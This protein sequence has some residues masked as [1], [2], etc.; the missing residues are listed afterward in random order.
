MSRNLSC[1]LATLC[2]LGPATP[3]AAAVFVVDNDLG[4][5]PDAAAT[6]GSLGWAVWSANNTAGPDQI[7]FAIPGLGPVTILAAEE[8]LLTDPG[9]LID[10]F[11]QAGSSANTN[12][13]PGP[14]D[15][16]L[17]ISVDGS[18]AGG[19]S[20][21]RIETDDVT[22]RGL[23]VHSGP[24][25]EISICMMSIGCTNN[26][27]QGNFLGTEITGTTPLPSGWLTWDTPYCAGVHIANRAASNFVGPDA[28]D[29]ADRN[30]ISGER[31]GDDPMVG[32]GVLFDGS[33]GSPSTNSVA[34]NLI[35]TDPS[36]GNPVP[37][38]NGVM[39]FSGS[40]DNEIANNVLA[41]NAEWGLAMIGF[42]A[43]A[44]S[45]NRIRRNFVGLDPTTDLPVP[46]G[47]DDGDLGGRPSGVDTGGQFRYQIAEV[48]TRAD[49]CG[50]GAIEGGEECDDGGTD[51]GDGCNSSCALEAGWACRTVSGVSWCGSMAGA[52]EVVVTEIMQNPG[53]VNDSEG[54][55]FEIRNASGRDLSLRGW[56]ISDDDTDGFV[57]EDGHL[58]VGAHVV[59]CRNGD[60]ATNGNVGGRDVPRRA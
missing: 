58:P 13:A 30:L 2:L 17:M 8:Y 20:V 51:D 40:I 15:T 41:G 45:S 44:N 34:D 11:S 32:F 26:R 42:T 49:Y 24:L 52:G 57:L 14:L 36:G 56:R 7:S 35:G 33:G 6:T 10:G 28:G 59:L 12:P 27:I 19:F 3:A 47:S 53:C 1:I 4:D 37:N 60:G 23:N 55:W 46:N 25:F 43:G 9:T 16:S 5:A 29:P 22:I 38:T 21:F 18:V 31:R 54:E 39:F 48:V 50:N